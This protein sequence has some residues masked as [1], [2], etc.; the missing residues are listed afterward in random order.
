MK[1]GLLIGTFLFSSLTVGAQSRPLQNN[2]RT[3]STQSEHRMAAASVRPSQAAVGAPTI[4]DYAP[5]SGPPGTSVTIHGNG[6]GAPDEDSYVSVIST[7]TNQYTKWPTTSW[8]DTEIVVSVPNNM[9]VGKV[10]I[11]VQAHYVVAAGWWAFTVGVPPVVTASSPVFGLAGT[12]VTLE[13]SGFGPP[14]ETSHVSVW[15]YTTHLTTQWPVTSWKDTEIVVPVP[16]DA[17]SGKLYL[18]VVVNKL[19]S[20]DQKPFTV[21]IPPTITSYSPNFGMPGKTSIQIHGTGFG[22]TAGDSHVWIMTPGVSYTAWPTTSWSDTDIT[23]PVPN[24]IPLGRI[25]F[26]VVVNKLES[27][28]PKP[29]TV[30]IPPAIADYSPT[31][32]DNG[33]N[34]TIHGTGFGSPG[35]GS[36]VQA[37]SIATNLW[38][39]WPTTSWR[40]K[41][42]IVH[43]PKNT[44]TGLFYF[45]VTAKTLESMNPEPFTVGSPPKITGLS[46][47]AG[48]P[49]TEITILGTGF[50]PSPGAG[51]ITVQSMVT[52]AYTDWPT[53]SWSDTEITVSVPN[54]TPNGLVYFTVT[55]NSLASM[56]P[57]PFTVGVPPAVTDYSPMFGNPGTEITIHGTNFGSMPSGGQLQIQSMVTGDYTAWPTTN[58]TDTEITVQVPRNMP[59]GLVYFTIFANKLASVSPWPFTVG[60]PPII[61]NY[62]PTVVSSGTVLTIDGT[63]FGASSSSGFVYMKSQSGVYVNLTPSSWTDTQIVVVIPPLAPAGWSY[64]YVGAAGLQ[65]IDTYPLQVQ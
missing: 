8:T 52:S 2:S 37:L 25:Y 21:G 57:W 34:I 54:N 59:N 38:E 65:S 41:N 33:T 64:L 12:V 49:G 55:G 61:S 19:E 63:G 27:I 31:S 48:N 26:S 22:R 60:T 35:V 50:G 14:L 46:P 53:T 15:S 4:H 5:L 42:I 20:V 24:T 39:R 51:K 1:I 30:G 7:V 40:D 47:L 6:F 28:D 23:V 9:P 10:Y 44:H 17:W 13:G 58:W 29:F 32:G 36:Y 18:S 43:V 16:A 56:N 11:L 3:L 62:Y 45:T